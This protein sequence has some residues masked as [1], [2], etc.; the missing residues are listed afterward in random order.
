MLKKT[1]ICHN[2]L[3]VLWVQGYHMFSHFFIV[4]SSVFALVACKYRRGDLVHSQLV[5]PHTSWKRSR[6]ITHVTEAPQSSVFRI[7]VLSYLHPLCSCEITAFFGWIW[8]LCAWRS[9]GNSVLAWWSTC[10]RT[11][12][13][14]SPSATLFP[15]FFARYFFQV[16]SKLHWHEEYVCGLPFFCLCHLWKNRTC[17][18]TLQQYGQAW[19][20]TWV[21]PVLWSFWSRTGCSW[22]RCHCASLLCAVLRRLLSKI[23]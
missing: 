4:L 8:H 20:E 18:E 5:N 19:Y 9:C 11:P 2:Y 16:T 17:R 12:C 22:R 10:G 23:L 7:Y 6:I 21:G 15:F 3:F 13:T 14:C 1:C